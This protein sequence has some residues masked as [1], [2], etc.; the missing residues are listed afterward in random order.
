MVVCVEN[1]VPQSKHHLKLSE[2]DIIEGKI[3]GNESMQGMECNL[4]FLYTVT[5]SRENGFLEGSL[6]GQVGIFP[7]PC[8]QEIRMKS[9]E[10]RNNHL[11]PPSRSG[12][13][14]AKNGGK[15]GTT[16][17]LKKV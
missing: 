2:G 13:G 12:G 6:R 16:Q 9:Y 11:A 17:P 5:G 15:K 4:V 14:G 7:A 8:V 10:N 1:F 3:I